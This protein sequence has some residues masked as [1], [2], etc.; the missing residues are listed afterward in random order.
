VFSESLQQKEDKL[1]RWVGKLFLLYFWLII[2]EGVL[3]KW[4][5]PGAS[6]ILLVVRDPIAILIYFWG[7]RYVPGS[8]RFWMGSAGIM[9]L[10]TFSFASIQLMRGGGWPQVLTALYGIRTYWLHIP[11]VGVFCGVVDRALL[12]NLVRG[13]AVSAVANVVLM[14]FQFASPGDSFLNRGSGGLE[15]VQIGVSGD[16]I[17]PPGTFTYATGPS[18]FLPIAL[19]VALC[20]V[21]RADNTRKRYLF[22]VILL[23]LI[24]IPLSGSRTLLFLEVCVLFAALPMFLRLGVIGKNIG[25]ISA[26]ILLLALL[27][28]VSETSRLAFASFSERW[29]SAS[30]YDDQH[31]SGGSVVTSRVSDIVEGGLD[32]MSRVPFIGLGIGLG[33]NVGSQLNVGQVDFLLAEYEWARIIMEC[34]PLLG[35]LILVWRFFTACLFVAQL[36]NMPSRSRVLGL[37]LGG[38]VVAY[39]IFGH[40]KQPTILGLVTLALMLGFGLIRVEQMSMV[41]QGTANKGISNL[42]RRRTKSGL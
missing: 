40:I 34:G 10:L 21:A 6:D 30:D 15:N 39:I 20:A 12:R 38:V 1:R 29:L 19:A 11:M 18:Y 2:L 4:V 32:S 13:I 42:N 31:V 23:C 9:A 17:R 8:L 27:F 3:R 24:A 22:G 25:S 36:M 37:I 26:I 16:L 5:F 28:A 33:T 41:V 7:L 35:G 14:F